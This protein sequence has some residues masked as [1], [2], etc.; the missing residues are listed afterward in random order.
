MSLAAK[1]CASI[2]IG[3]ASSSGT[4]KYPLLRQTALAR[5]ALSRLALSRTL[6]AVALLLGLLPLN[7]FGAACCEIH[8]AADGMAINTSGAAT[9]SA[10]AHAASG[11]Y[12]GHHHPSMRMSVSDSA[13]SSDNAA[14][15]PAAGGRRSAAIESAR[16]RSADGSCCSTSPKTVS[17]CDR[18][19]LIVFEQPRFEQSLQRSASEQSRVPGA[20]LL[21]PSRASSVNLFAPANPR[22]RPHLGNHPGI[23]T[24]SADVPALLVLRV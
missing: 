12:M 2:K 18:G 17:A 14:S 8:C 20:Q 24:A 23:D 4:E 16:P 19:L 11:R 6:I 21:K 13:A 7:A 22:Y 1:V 10:A 5:T 9:V 15:Q 3:L